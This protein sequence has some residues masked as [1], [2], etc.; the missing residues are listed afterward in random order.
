MLVKNTTYFF[1]VLIGSLVAVGCKKAPNYAKEPVIEFSSLKVKPV[2]YVK[3]GNTERV[4]SLW[5]TVKFKDG[6]GDIGND[7]ATSDF[8]YFCDV[9]KKTNGIY[10]RVDYFDTIPPGY[11][12]KLPLFSPYNITG[13]IDGI[14][15]NKPAAF[16]APL[17]GHPYPITYPY[18]KNDTLQFHVQIRDRAGNYSNWIETSEYVV[19]KTF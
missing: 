6:D 11:N 2:T 9:Y 8:D 5:I 7:P 16:L 12:G 14:I 17:P 18:H 3:Q 13:P 15:T 4:D 19:W 10:T 1:L